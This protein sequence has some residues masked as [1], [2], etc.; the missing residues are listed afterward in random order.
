MTT[1]VS[2]ASGHN[3]V[4]EIKRAVMW[5]LGEAHVA[6]VAGT[7]SA[8]QADRAKRAEVGARQAARGCAEAQAGADRAVS[9]LNQDK[10]DEAQFVLEVLIAAAARSSAQEAAASSAAAETLQELAGQAVKALSQA[11]DLVSLAAT[12]SWPVEPAWLA[13]TNARLTTLGAEVG[14]LAAAA[15]HA[16]QMALEASASSTQAAVILDQVQSAIEIAA[17]NREQ[18]AAIAKDSQI[19]ASERLNTRPALIKSAQLTALPASAPAM[20]NTVA[21]A[22]ACPLAAKPANSTLNSSSH[23]TANRTPVHRIPWRPVPDLAP[24]ALTR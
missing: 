7:D 21:D 19:M 15:R 10:A 12:P 9:L 6:A 5:R 3:Q 18:A 11:H 2:N 23:A 8:G 16:G 17:I 13:R 1:A 24:G 14:R 22:N 4:D 20:P